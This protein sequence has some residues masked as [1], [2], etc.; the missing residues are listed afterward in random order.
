MGA[1]FN[2][3]NYETFVLEEVRKE[4]KKDNPINQRLRL[5]NF[6]SRPV[7]VKRGEKKGR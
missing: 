6:N 5:I 3:Q 1:E 7:K 2:L 4:A